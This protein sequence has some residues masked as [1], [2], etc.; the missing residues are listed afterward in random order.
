MI[1]FFLW[2]VL[3]SLNQ[4]CILTVTYF[5]CSLIGEIINTVLVS[6]IKIKTGLYRLEVSQKIRA[7]ALIHSIQDQE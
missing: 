3:S 2:L 4:L 6:M 5:V 1:Q 7:E